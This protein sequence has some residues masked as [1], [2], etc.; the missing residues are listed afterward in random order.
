MDDINTVIE[1]KIREALNQLEKSGDIALV[2]QTLKDACVLIR[3]SVSEIYCSK[4]FTPREIRYFSQL[5]YEASKNES[6][7]QGEL[8]A[9]TGYDLEESHELGRKINEITAYW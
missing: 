1:S 2:D 8:Q 3:E 7:F 5:A 6:M 4:Y 9:V